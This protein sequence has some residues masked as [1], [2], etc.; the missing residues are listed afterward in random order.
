MKPV[1]CYGLTTTFGFLLFLSSAACAQS[2]AP[3]AETSNMQ[4]VETTFRSLCHRAP[5]PATLNYYSDALDEQST[6]ETQVRVDIETT[7]LRGAQVNPCQK[8]SG[9]SEL[10][11]SIAN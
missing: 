4:F 6:T 3:E 2:A 1:I 5:D 9:L 7:C 11:R 10:C 8:A